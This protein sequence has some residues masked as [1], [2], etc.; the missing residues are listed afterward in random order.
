MTGGGKLSKNF[1]LIGYPLGHSISPEI[2]SRL[3]E[4]SGVDAQYS[5]FEIQPEKFEDKISFLKTLDGFNITIPYKQRILP[6]LDELDL[7]A[8]RC[9]AV[10]TVKCENGRLSGFNTDAEGFLRALKS[11]DIELSGKVLLC[12]AG[13]VAR[14]MACEALERGCSLVVATRDVSGAQLCADDLNKLFP[15]SDIKAE[16]LSQVSGSFDLILNGTPA[17]MHPHPE[18]CPVSQKVAQNSAAVFDSVYNPR[19]TLLI[20]TAQK[21]GAKTQGGTTMLV[22]QAAA[23]QEIYTG[24]RFRETD[25][26]ALCRDMEALITQRYGIAQGGAV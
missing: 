11:A 10:N 9:G 16:S 6:F 22:W 14:M 1:C 26:I 2:H 19:E 17:G 8:R 25:I 20:R 15:H 3:F 13:G 24:A 18:G 4:I 23:A 5:L 12:G 21:A 7:R